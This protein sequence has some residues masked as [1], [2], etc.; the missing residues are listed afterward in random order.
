[1]KIWDIVRTVGTGVL[2]SVAGPAAPLVIGAINAILPSDKQLPDDAT[3]Q[4]AQDAI[5]TLPAADRA[6]IMD[7]E[8]DVQITEIKESHSTVR[9]MLE[10][11]AKNPQ[12][13]RPYIAKQAFH[14]IAFSIIATTGMWS[15]AVLMDNQEMV[16]AIMDGWPF[17]VG[18]N[19]TL[20]SVLLHYFGV[21]RKEHKQ[22]MDAANGQSPVDGI[23][24]MIGSLFKK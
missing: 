22:K 8:F 6:A 23:A 4:Q 17:I 11:D 9:T 7:K 15:Y 13:T 12:T 1:M 10:S 24:G 20:A 14:V 2:A 19:A 16:K 5:A 18:V 21:L 3:G